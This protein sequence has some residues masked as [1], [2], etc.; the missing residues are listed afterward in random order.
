M[1]A[2]QVTRAGGVPVLLPPARDNEDSLRTSIAR[3][4]ESADL[5]VLS[6]G[7]SVGKYDLVEP[8]LAE[9]GATF[10]FTSVAIRPGKPAVYGK[11]GATP[12]LGLPGNPLSTLLTF[13][14]FARPA[15]EL[16]SGATDSSLT[17][18][19][20]PLAAEI[21]QRDLPLTVFHPATIASGLAR[22]LTSQGS[23]DL[24][25]IARAAGW[26]V[27][28]PHVTAIPAGTLVPFFPL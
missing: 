17:L 24:F 9:R 13:E 11:V 15:I 1:L 27:V 20:A 16:L 2:A 26:V 10:A 25:T 4:L 21:R 14:L 3:A 18:L 23:G 19:Q 6:G 28:D 8:I 12:F 22:T 5:I 7:V